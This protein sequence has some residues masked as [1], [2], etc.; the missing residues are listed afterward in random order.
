RDPGGDRVGLRV[1]RPEPL[2]PGIPPPVRP[3]APRLSRALRPGARRCRSRSKTCRSRSRAAPSGAAIVFPSDGLPRTPPMISRRF[4][5]L[6]AAALLAASLAW[7]A[8]NPVSEGFV[9]LFNGKDLAGWK[10][11]DGDNGH[12]KVV[13][14]VIDYDAES[15]AAGDKNLWTERAYGDF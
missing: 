15:E 2:H 14:G 12:W 9:P 4:I 11:P 10:V 7:A 5:A 6:P 3:D 1:L 8:D 13:G